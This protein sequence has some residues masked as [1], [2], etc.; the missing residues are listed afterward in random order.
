MGTKVYYNIMYLS[1]VLNVNVWLFVF[2]PPTPHPQHVD[3]VV[4]SQLRE[5]FQEKVSQLQKGELKT[6]ED[7]FSFACP[8]FMSPIPPDYDSLPENYNKVCLSVSVCPYV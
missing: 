5:R 3:E 8:K 4:N 2:P 6:F 1:L 7:M